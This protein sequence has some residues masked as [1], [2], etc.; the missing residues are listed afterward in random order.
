MITWTWICTLSRRKRLKSDLCMYTQTV[1][2]LIVWY[3]RKI[4]KPCRI[5]KLKG[6]A[7]NKLLCAMISKVMCSVQVY[8]RTQH[9]SSQRSACAIG[10]NESYHHFNSVVAFFSP[11]KKSIKRDKCIL[12]DTFY[13]TVLLCSTLISIREGTQCINF[14]PW[15]RRCKLKKQENRKQTDTRILRRIKVTKK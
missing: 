7:K 4:L 14:W 13:L 12:N 10:N 11:K 1:K 6:T 15:K 2:S 9:V 8:N 5:W 3:L